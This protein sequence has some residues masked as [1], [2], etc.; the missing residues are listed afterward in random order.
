[1]FARAFP[2][3]GLSLLTDFFEEIFG[4]EL[5]IELS[6]SEELRNVDS[7]S[8]VPPGVFDCSTRWYELFGLLGCLGAVPPRS[9]LGIVAPR[10]VSFGDLSE[11]DIVE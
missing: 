6:D 7:S 8:C 11:S 10:G 3:N 4:F 9:V 1:M 5:V 2:V